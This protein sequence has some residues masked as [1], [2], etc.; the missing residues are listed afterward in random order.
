MYGQHCAENECAG[1][2]RHR[3]VVTALV[4]A[5]FATAHITETVTERHSGRTLARR[6]GR[7]RHSRTRWQRHPCA[8]GAGLTRSTGGRENDKLFGDAGNDASV[9]GWAWLVGSTERG[10]GHKRIV[11]R[12]S[13]GFNGVDWFA[14]MMKCIRGGRLDPESVAADYRL[15]FLLALATTGNVR[16]S[17][18]QLGDAFR[19]RGRMWA[20]V[21]RDRGAGVKPASQRQDGTGAAN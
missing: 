16:P 7:G 21:R 10:R 2:H 6:R 14:G 1:G 4:L 5:G 19:C 11:A 17:N 12:V 13:Q 9:R 15:G 8:A 18:S 20:R 3:S